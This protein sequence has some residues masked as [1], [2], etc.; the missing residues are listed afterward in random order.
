M[1]QHCKHLNLASWAILVHGTTLMVIHRHYMF[2]LIAQNAG[3][4]RVHY[5]H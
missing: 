5:E 2:R 4:V 3:A 1:R